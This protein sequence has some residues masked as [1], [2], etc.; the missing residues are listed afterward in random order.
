MMT[1]PKPSSDFGVRCGSGLT[2]PFLDRTECAL[3]GV[4]YTS[5]VSL[6]LWNA[7]SSPPRSVNE[8]KPERGGR[9]SLRSID[10]TRGT[11]NESRFRCYPRV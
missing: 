7:V 4:R 6:V 3:L 11:R 9:S 1:G 10:P 5:R 8:L 2:N